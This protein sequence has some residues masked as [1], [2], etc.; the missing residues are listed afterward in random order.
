MMK[1]FAGC[2]LLLTCSL[3]HAADYKVIANPAV[4]ASEISGDDL[5]SIFLQTKTSL[6]GSGHVEPV[7]AKEGGTHEAFLKE[8]L[9]K[10]DTA[11]STYYR[12][13]V[14]TGKA[15][16]PKSFASDAEIVGYVG[17]TKGAVGYISASAP[18]AGVKILSV[19]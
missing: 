15:V 12:S 16:M 18:A 2:A 8:C 10:S 3:A 5:K 17:K 9:S 7:L 6:P 1:L 4:A 11:L 13:L 19:K 14:F